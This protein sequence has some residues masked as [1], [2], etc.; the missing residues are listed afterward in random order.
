MVVRRKVGEVAGFGYLRALEKYNYMAK[1]VFLGLLILW[2]ATW[3]GSQKTFMEI[4]KK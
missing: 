4:L 2:K 3:G 1:Y